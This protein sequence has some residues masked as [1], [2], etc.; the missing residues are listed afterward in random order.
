MGACGSAAPANP[1]AS[2]DKAD[3]WKNATPTML[4]LFTP[5]YGQLITDGVAFRTYSF[6]A[7]KAWR[8]TFRMD[9]TPYDGGITPYLFTGDET[10]GQVGNEFHRQANVRTSELYLQ[11]DT[12][13]PISLVATTMRNRLNGRPIDPAVFTVSA[14]AELPCQR[15]DSADCPFGLRCMYAPFDAANATPPMGL[16]TPPTACATVDECAAI[17][18]ACGAWTCDYNPDV[19]LQGARLRRCSCAT[20]G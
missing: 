6:Y 8:V 13:G 12:D 9:I 4:P 3:D 20:P 16:C 5:A 11:S 14:S 19:T 7:Q 18:I 2:A 1:G 17:P 10:Y 15:P